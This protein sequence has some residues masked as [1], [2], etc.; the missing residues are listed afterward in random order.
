MTEHRGKRFKTSGE[1]APNSA[2]STRT[3]RFKSSNQQQPTPAPQPQP[4]R[5]PDVVRTE[6]PF[7]GIRSTS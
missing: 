1:I 6:E 5:I 7:K 4:Q 2:S 3:P